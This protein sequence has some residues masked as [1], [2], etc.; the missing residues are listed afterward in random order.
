MD[1]HKKSETKIHCFFLNRI[2]RH[3]VFDDRI[4]KNN[5]NDHIK[6]LISEVFTKTTLHVFVC[7]LCIFV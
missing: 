1:G 5:L 6:A 4:Q 7:L 3:F 2:W